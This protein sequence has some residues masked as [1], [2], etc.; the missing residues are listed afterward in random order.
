MKARDQTS[1]CRL[2]V[3][4]ALGLAL[5]AVGQGR[6]AE[7]DPIQGALEKGLRRLEEGSGNYVK[8]RKCFS[9]HHQALTLRALTA[10]QKRGFAIDGKRLEEQRAFSVNTFAPKLA[11][12][13]KGNRVEGGNTMAAYALFALAGTEYPPDEVTAA[14]VDYLLVRQRSDGS[15]PAL[16]RRPPSEGSPFTNAALALLAFQ[17]YG[18]KDAERLARIKN[19]TTR[20][21]E[22][23]QSAQPKDTEDRAFALRALVTLEAAASEIEKA[24]ATLVKEQHE[25]GS[26]AQ[27]PGKPGDAYA[28]GIVL[29]ALR[30]A[31]MKPTDAVYRKGVAYLVKTQRPDGAWLVETRSRPV[32]VFFDNGDPGGKSQFISFAATGWAVLA[33]LETRSVR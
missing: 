12:V 15:W 13:R 32:Q 17:H 27:L 25:D 18:G 10:A 29:L 9:C 28:T 19:A 2:G 31:G 7:P 14:L 26:W 4:L 3:L 30:E 24:R 33:L 6:G 23:L 22:W 20:A 11:A 8:N 21:K 5:G 1:W 16:A